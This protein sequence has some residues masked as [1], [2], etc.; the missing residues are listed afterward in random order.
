MIRYSPL[1][2]A[3]CMASTHAVALEQCEFHFNGFGTAGISRLGGADDALGFGSSGQTTDSW[4]GDQLSKLAAQFQYGLTDKLGVTAQVV[5][6]AEQD[7]WD[8][9]LEWLYL[10]YQ[11]NDQLTVRA[12]RLRPA[13]FLFSE[14]L[15]VGYSYPWLRLPEEAYG[16]VQVSNYEGADAL[17]S[18]PLSFG[19]L[20]FQAS[21]GNAVN[22]ELYSAVVDERWD[23]DLKGNMVGSVS[24][25]T[26]NAGTFRYSYSEV[27]LGINKMPASKTKF[28]SLGYR[29]DNGTWVTNAET[30][31]RRVDG[32]GT[33]HAFYVMAGRRF[34]DFLPHL[35]Y[36][37][38]DKL[39]GGRQAS[40]TYGLNYNLTANVT[41]K[42]EY[43][44]VD[45][46]K[47]DEGYLGVFVPAYNTFNPTFDGDVVSIGAD[48]VF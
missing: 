21:Y 12:G 19:R 18:L 5:T 26:N 48:F 38:A 9:N 16:L 10:A 32:L 36:A 2:L 11:M 4:R 41:L 35:T 27:D 39:H 42:G 29:F 6:K 46:T 31:S 7:S 33:D 1:A 24:L 25:D 13:M 43:K 40:W 23:M 14:T 28:V 45:V 30:V 44:R 20:N 22:R 15:D 34:G 17:Y 8:V 37:Q 47:A 3:I